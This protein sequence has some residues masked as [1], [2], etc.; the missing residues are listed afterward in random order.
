M[1]WDAFTAGG[2][3]VLAGLFVLFM[4]DSVFR[5]RIRILGF[6]IPSKIGA[7]CFGVVGALLCYAAL[8]DAEPEGSHKPINLVPSVP[9]RIEGVPRSADGCPVTRGASVDQQ[10]Q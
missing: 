7:L 5:P 9:F 4:E 8:P 10:C 1:N 3:F 2:V 6:R